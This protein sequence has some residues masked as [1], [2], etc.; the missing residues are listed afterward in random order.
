MKQSVE[1]N[2]FENFK[3]IASLSILLPYFKSFIKKK[4]FPKNPVN[5]DMGI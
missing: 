1:S 4:D 3:A 5:L 2:F